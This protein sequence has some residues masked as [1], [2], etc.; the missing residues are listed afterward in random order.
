M[1]TLD[2]FKYLDPTTSD[3]SSFLSFSSFADLTQPRYQDQDDYSLPSTFGQVCD[4]SQESGN[5]KPYFQSSPTPPFTCSD[6]GSP[7]DPFSIISN[8]FS[9]IIDSPSNNGE[10]GIFHT[11]SKA[12]PSKLSGPNHQS[13]RSTSSSSD[14][15]SPVTPS[16][17]Y[18]SSVDSLAT[19]A[20]ENDFYLPPSSHLPSPGY[21]WDDQAFGASSSTS[22]HNSPPSPSPY[23]VVSN[24]SL[25]T[26][27]PRVIKQIMSMPALKEEE[28]SNSWFDEFLHD[29]D[30][31]VEE[32]L[33]EDLDWTL[34]FPE[35][36]QSNN[37][38]S[39]EGTIFQAFTEQESNDIS[40]LSFDNIQPSS[41]TLPTYSQVEAPSIVPDL[42]FSSVDNDDVSHFYQWMNDNPVD[43]SASTVDMTSSNLDMTTSTLDMSS[44]ST[45]GPSVS[46]SSVPSTSWGNYPAQNG[47]AP[48]AVFQNDLR[49]ATAPDLGIWSDNSSLGV[50]GPGSMMRR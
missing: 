44:A 23:R 5:S 18:K 35:F 15:N 37:E 19:L 11:P 8:I 14:W 49:P 28:Q 40:N 34:S 24:P 6:V 2:L 13:Q 1:S 16:L 47:I 50:P 32:K 20:P 39:T 38:T 29:E 26:R 36:N 22:A 3:D 12:G 7:Q 33:A 27:H 10:F 43:M 9:P 45:S 21:G 46:S 17:T 41:S 4:Y 48:S 25:G 42:S 30:A 31:K